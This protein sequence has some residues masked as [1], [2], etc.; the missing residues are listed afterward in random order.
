MDV[1]DTGVLPILQE[2][3][4]KQ[5]ANKNIEPG[6]SANIL[7]LPPKKKYHDFGFAIFLYK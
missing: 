7:P 3:K 6:G 4:S 5:D 1:A 2:V